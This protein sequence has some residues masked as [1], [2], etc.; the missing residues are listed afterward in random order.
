MLA[1]KSQSNTLSVEAV[2]RI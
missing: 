2:N 1:R